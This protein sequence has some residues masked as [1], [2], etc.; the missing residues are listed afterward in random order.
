MCLLFIQLYFLSRTHFWTVA[1]PAPMP[2]ASNRRKNSPLRAVPP[3]ASDTKEWTLYASGSS[4]L[5]CEAETRMADQRLQTPPKRG[6]V[7]DSS[8]GSSCTPP[9]RSPKGSCT[10]PSRSPGVISPTARRATF[11]ELKSGAEW[12]KRRILADCGGTATPR[13][14]RHAANARLVT[15]K[16]GDAVK[17]PEALAKK[18][19]RRHQQRR[20]ASP[21]L[22]AGA[23]SAVGSPEQPETREPVDPMPVPVSDA[24]APTAEAGAPPVPP[25]PQQRGARFT[26]LARGRRSPHSRRLLE[27]ADPDEIM[28]EALTSG[29][30]TAFEAELAALV[31][32]G[33]IR[34]NDSGAAGANASPLFSLFDKVSSGAPSVAK[35]R[36]RLMRSLGSATFEAAH[37]RLQQAALSDGQH[38]DALASGEVQQLLG[39]RHREILPEMLK[40]IFL[41]ERIRAVAPW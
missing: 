24:A 7:G 37:I 1:P 29:A 2:K 21:P 35:L 32:A 41:E 31:Q 26:S 11:S 20:N 28:R 25:T 40:L 27:L 4:G 36:E 16:G 5:P 22:K 19:D 9:S 6:H 17:V 12:N 15:S 10:P 14:Q 13:S 38:D 33:S 3:G 8:K 30:Q 18:L 23:H 34:E 39:I